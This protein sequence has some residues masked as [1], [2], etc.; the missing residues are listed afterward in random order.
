MLQ[1][2]K[3]YLRPVEESD[4]EDLVTWLN[5]QSVSS[6]LLRNW[7]MSQYR[8]KLWY[9]NR[10]DTLKVLTYAICLRSGSK[11]IGFIEITDIHWVHQVGELWI[12]IGDKAQWG[13]GLATEALLL[14]SDYAFKT[15]GLRKLH[16]KVRDDNEA[17]VKL[18]QKCGFVQ[19][20]RF[21]KEY[22][23]EGRY[24]DLLRMAIFNPS[25]NY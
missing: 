22:L 14:M 10:K 19:E 17:A 16:I 18:Y 7:P 20:G 23:A 6:G 13:Q 12:F 15:L 2:E 5:D 1:G 25:R 8:A 3:I 9:E 4:L 11:S 21:I 24:I